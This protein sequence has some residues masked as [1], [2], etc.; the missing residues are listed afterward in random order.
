[1]DTEKR[2]SDVLN[3]EVSRVGLGTW[4]IGGWMWGGT[5][6]EDS[7]RAILE[8]LDRGIN[9]VDTAPV[10]GFGRSEQ[11]VGR[12]LKE[13]GSRD[14][15]ILSTKVGLEWDTDGNV[16]RN[17]TPQR[18]RREIEDS[19][20]RLQTD[21]V[22][23]YFVHWP[24]PLVAFEETAEVMN[25]L[26]QER[27]IRAIGVSNFSPMQMDAFRRAAPLQIVQPPYN[28]FERG[29]EDDILPYCRANNIATMTYGT[30]CRG[31]LSGKM[32]GDRTF[33]GDDLRQ[34]DPKFKPPRFDQ[35]LKA[36]DLLDGYV[37][38]RYGRKVIHLAVRWVLDQN[39]DIALWG[40]RRP[41]QLEALAALPG[42][43]LSDEDHEEIDK[44]LETTI[45]EPVGPEFMA[46]PN[47][48]TPG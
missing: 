38:R 41:E 18:I 13:Y 21:Y 43:M 6:E 31:L 14:R 7:V 19:L 30:L 28:L 29:I 26:F 16:T 11:I 44:I 35:Y 48:E 47:R 39:I 34:I 42:L 45:D 33:E 27:K 1:M 22:D 37:S 5:D 8:A 24:D 25:E 2:V 10:Y 36:V 23:I 17:A 12:A 40:A 9:V 3:M 4:A 32:T 15:V 46:P 20:E